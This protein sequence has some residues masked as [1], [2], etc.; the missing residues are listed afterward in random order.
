MSTSSTSNSSVRAALRFAL[1]SIVVF[2]GVC[3][4]FELVFYRLGDNWP[5]EKVI[6]EQARTGATYSQR[7][8]NA[9]SAYKALGVKTFAPRIVVLGNSRML[10]IM[11]HSVPKPSE[12]YNAAV[13]NTGGGEVDS[14]MDVLRA[15]DDEHK[16]DA[17][18]IGIDPLIFNPYSHDNA[19]YSGLNQL[20]RTVTSR[21][22]IVERIWRRYSYYA[23]LSDKSRWTHYLLSE[24]G[25][26]GI[27]VD[28]RMQGAG[29]ARDGSYHYPEDVLRA[30]PPEKSALE[31]QRELENAQER[32]PSC[33][34]LDEA[35]LGRFVSLLRYCRGR[36]IRVVGV[37]MPSREDLY[38]AFTTLPSH[39]AFF[40]EYRTRVPAIMQHM[41]YQCFDFSSPASIGLT[42]D[43]F[44]DAGHPREKASTEIMARLLKS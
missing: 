12:F 7:Y 20:W 40:Q 38:D 33:D 37:L 1:A 9:T 36:G 27:G 17:V 29:Y 32:Y 28:A 21:Y 30:H 6:A 43:D 31:W 39:R 22:R 44:L 24:A 11:D 41:G 4:A 16:P 19:R 10:Q 14:M 25:K 23:L 26:E 2:F 8:I 35:L 13:A 42:S 34:K 3:A 15:L 18:I 5:Y